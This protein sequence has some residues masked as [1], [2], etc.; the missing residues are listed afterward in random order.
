[1]K[2]IS[3]FSGIEAAT[4]AW[5]PLGWEPLFFCE[6]ED[7]P[8]AV[9][10]HH[11]PNVPN[12]RDVTTINEGKINVLKSRSGGKIDLLVGGSPCQSFSTA[13]LRKGLADPR[14]NLMYQY[15]RLVKAFRPK[16]IVWENVPG[17]LSSGGGR[18]FG[19]LLSALAQFGYGLA[20]RVLDSQHFGVPQRRR[21]VF[22]VGCFGDAKSAFN[23][24]FE[25]KGSN[26]D[27]EKSGKARKNDFS[28]TQT[29]IR[30]HAGVKHILD[31][32]LAGTLCARD[33]K[34]IAADDFVGGSQKM[35]VEPHNRVRRLTPK[36]CERLQGFPDDYTK[37]A[38]NGKAK[39]DCPNGLRYKALGNSMAVPVM[40]WIGERIME[41]EGIPLPMDVTSLLEKYTIEVPIY[42]A[43]IINHTVQLMLGWGDPLPGAPRQ[44]VRHPMFLT[45]DFLSLQLD[46]K[47][48]PEDEKKTIMEFILTEVDKALLEPN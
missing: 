12:L 6:I 36:E 19:T 43:K 47:K 1:M 32:K 14:G 20:Y 26:R 39:E 29:S 40:R 46:H 18:D 41:V 25:Q 21:R 27:S 38:W 23:V 24:L 4:V 42:V 17:A 10:K 45:M 31:H 2:Y 7:F 16:W 35:V 15:I 30:K 9:L 33:Y 5:H 37:I 3:L 13:G 28:K 8:S 48:I 22:V 44:W 11:Y 34:G